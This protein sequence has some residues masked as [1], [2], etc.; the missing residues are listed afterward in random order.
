[1][2]ETAKKFN[3]NKQ[4][5]EIENLKKQISTLE[6]YLTI[7]KQEFSQY[8]KSS[9][10]RTASNGSIT[11]YVQ[12]KTSIDYDIAKLEEKLEA[13]L[14]SEFVDKTYTI[15]DWKAFKKFLKENDI[16]A[17]ELKPYISV[18]KQVNEEKLSKLYDSGEITLQD[19]EGCYNAKVTNSVAMRLGNGKEAKS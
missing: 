14:L 17:K 2:P 19:L 7:K 5:E 10:E 9:G 15:P 12:Q 18:E 13:D 8:F 1:M 6:S 4:L 11:V 3:V 16:P